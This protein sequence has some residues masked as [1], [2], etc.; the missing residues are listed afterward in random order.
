MGRNMFIAGPAA[1]ASSRP[2]VVSL[3]WIDPLM[4]GGTF[5]TPQVYL[6]VSRSCYCPRASLWT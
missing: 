4:L 3:E 2:R 1:R 6:K 5:P